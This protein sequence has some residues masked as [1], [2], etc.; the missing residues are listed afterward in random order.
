MI[1]ERLT[2]IKVGFRSLTEAI[3]TTIPAGRMRAA[4]LFAVHPATISRIL[5]WTAKPLLPKRQAPF[6]QRRIAYSEHSLNVE[7]G[8]LHLA[9]Q[10]PNGLTPTAWDLSA[11]MLTLDP[12]I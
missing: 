1:M 2:E 8:R 12:K 10:L 5:A 4:R 9:I 6:T 11:E 3:D 7:C